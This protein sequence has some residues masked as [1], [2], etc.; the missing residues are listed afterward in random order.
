MPGFQRLLVG[1]V[2]LGGLVVGCGPGEARLPPL[3]PVTG[4]VKFRGLPAKKFRVIFN[5][6]SDIGR[7]QF[8]PSAITD[9]SGNFKL[10]SAKPDD[11]AP[12][13]DYQVTFLWPDHFN[14]GDEIE[15]K[16]EVDKLRGAYNN[17]QQS[18]F[19]ITVQPGV[20]TLPPFELN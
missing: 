13:G 10:K 14:T 2:L 15:L 9:D 4:T 8:S 12:A 7:L 1:C 20:N 6:V 16:P 19:R 5:P 11:G 17:P 18:R 3:H